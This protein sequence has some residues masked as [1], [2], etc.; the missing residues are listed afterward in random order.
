MKHRKPLRC[1]R[2]AKAGWGEGGL[3]AGTVPTG[4]PYNINIS[5]MI[6]S[7]IVLRS[8]YQRPDGLRPVAAPHRRTPSPYSGRLGFRRWI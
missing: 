2:R 8:R 1:K 3:R 6:A 5:D 7:P 4:W